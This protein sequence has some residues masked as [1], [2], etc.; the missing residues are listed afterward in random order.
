MK[1]RNTLG[2]EKNEASILTL[3]ALYFTMACLVY[4]LTDSRKFFDVKYSAMDS[5]FCLCAI[6]TAIGLASIVIGCAK[7][8]RWILAHQISI[9]PFVIIFF[10][11][12]QIDVE[13]NYVLENC[14][15]CLSIFCGASMLTFRLK[16]A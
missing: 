1:K 13:H 4:P 3:L 2:I 16:I 8:I 12:Y 14:L 11:R 10:F 5:I 15:V 7:T 6:G 9:L